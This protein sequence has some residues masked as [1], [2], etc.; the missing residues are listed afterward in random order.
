VIDA[1]LFAGAVHD[2]NDCVLA[3]AVALTEV[4]AA[5][6]AEGTIADEADEA[7]PVPDTFVAVTV[8]VYEVPLVKPVTVQDV[9]V[10][11]HVNEPGVEVTV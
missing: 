4:G 1:P 5:G 7:E 2:T 3:A 11:V 6:T 9:N 8:N 10:V